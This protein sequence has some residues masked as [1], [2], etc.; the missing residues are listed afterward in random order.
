M[1]IR[2]IIFSGLCILVWLGRW[3]LQ[4]VAGRE[5]INR[6]SPVYRRGWIWPRVIFDL[7][8]ELFASLIEIQSSTRS[9]ALSRLEW[10]YICISLQL[11]V[12]NWSEMRH[13]PSWDAG[14]VC[15]LSDTNKWWNPKGYNHDCTYVMVCE[16]LAMDDQEFYMDDYISQCFWLKIY[17]EYLIPWVVGR[18]QV[19]VWFVFFSWWLCI[20]ELLDRCPLISSM[21]VIHDYIIFLCLGKHVL[22]LLIFCSGM[23]WVDDT[24]CMILVHLSFCNH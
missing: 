10:V 24:L 22:N 3:T 5:E 20:N 17:E 11:M 14:F 12:V 8:W 13:V 2:V 1:P 18:S 7:D 9:T 19:V 16:P 21:Q 6:L 15:I 23:S 4:V